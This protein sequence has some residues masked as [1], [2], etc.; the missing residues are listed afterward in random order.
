MARIRQSHLN[1]VINDKSSSVVKVFINKRLIKWWV[2]Q[3]AWIFNNAASLYGKS[4]SMLQQQGYSCIR[5]SH[6]CVCR[7]SFAPWCNLYSIIRPNDLSSSSSMINYNAFDNGSEW[8]IVRNSGL[9][10]WRNQDRCKAVLRKGIR[11]GNYIIRYKN[12]IFIYLFNRI[13]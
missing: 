7:K 9:V 12:F 11:K 4:Q 13:R 1:L 5:A 6:R 3:H 2:S 10:Q 8:E